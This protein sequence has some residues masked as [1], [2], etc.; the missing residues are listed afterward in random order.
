VWPRGRERDPAI[1]SPMKSHLAFGRSSC[2]GSI[3]SA[4][5]LVG[6]ERGE[7]WCMLGFG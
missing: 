1:G 3:A 7:R 2:I 4:S 6:E 5:R